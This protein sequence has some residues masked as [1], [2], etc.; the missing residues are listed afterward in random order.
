[1]EQ[2]EDFSSLP[3]SAKADSI[4]HPE[5]RIQGRK[6]GFSNPYPYTLVSCKK[7]S[8]RLNDADECKTE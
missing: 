4:Q 5:E 6:L 7:K 8:G 1:M 2:K 3:F